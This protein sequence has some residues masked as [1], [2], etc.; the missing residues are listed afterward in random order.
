[1]AVQTAVPN[2]CLRNELATQGIVQVFDSTSS[3]E[4]WSRCSVTLHGQD[5]RQLTAA[6]CTVTSREACGTIEQLRRH[7]APGLEKD[8]LRTK[9]GEFRS[10]LE[11][12][13]RREHEVLRWMAEGKN[14]WE[15]SRILHISER[16]VYFHV[17]NILEKLEATCRSHAVSIAIKEG[18]CE[19]C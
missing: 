15:I 8:P 10:A 1:M 9:P 14:T 16:T 13:S 18:I 2:R 11:K 3:M 5:T 12:L 7:L 4:S 17:Q 19:L 6:S